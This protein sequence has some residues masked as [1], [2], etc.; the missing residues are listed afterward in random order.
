MTKKF[1]F[2]IYLFFLIILGP[3]IFGSEPCFFGVMRDS[4]TDCVLGTLFLGKYQ[5]N[6]FIELDITG[7][8]INAIELQVGS[9]LK[10]IKI[11][12][13]FPGINIDGQ[14]APIKLSADSSAAASEYTVAFTG[15][16]LKTKKIP[17][18]FWTSNTLK[19]E[20]IS[21]NKFILEAQDEQMLGRK[22]LDM[23][24]KTITAKNSP[25][26][27]YK[28][29]KVLNPIVL[30]PK[31]GSNFVTIVFPLVLEYGKDDIDTEASVF[32]VYD[33]K[34]KKIISSIF[35]HPEWNVRSKEVRVVKP[36]LFFSL[37][38]KTYFF[39]EYYGPWEYSGYAIFELETGK[40][41]LETY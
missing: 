10:K 9:L 38:G 39:S 11:H 41:M 32:F 27:A 3:N 34:T 2:L 40:K 16:S 26:Y 22:V 35:G 12:T 4:A 17:I 23:V 37:S 30:K 15:I 13:P 5:Q 33:V 28:L 6:N 21:A 20:P 25:K 14:S 24:H 1:I 7:K 8:S 31:D 18:F 36:V 19:L 29:K